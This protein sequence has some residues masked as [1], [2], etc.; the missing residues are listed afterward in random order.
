MG[1]IARF[2]DYNNYY[3]M[4]YDNFGKNVYITRLQ[5]GVLTDLAISAPITPLATGIYHNLRFTSAGNTL[6][7]YVNDLLI[8]TASDSTFPTWKIGV[9]THFNKAYFDDVVVRTAP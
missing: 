9:N 5:N 8:A 4:S 7:A 1:V 6:Q 3:S 2:V